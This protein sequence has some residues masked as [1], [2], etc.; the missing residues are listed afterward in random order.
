[1]AYGYKDGMVYI[2]DPASSIAARA[3]N[4]WELFKVQVKYY[5]AVDVP[6]RIKAGGIVSGGEYHQ[7]DFV[8][9]V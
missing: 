2:N 1:M 9:E 6:E 8:R 7:A 3:C 5:W 4:T